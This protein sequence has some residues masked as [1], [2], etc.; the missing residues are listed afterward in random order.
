MKA[1]LRRTNSHFLAVLSDI[2]EVELP[3][4]DVGAQSG[5]SS[6]SES[7]GLTA[8]ALL[9]QPPTAQPTYVEDFASLRL[10]A[11]PAPTIVE[12]RATGGH[13][14]LRTAI[15]AFRP[16]ACSL[17][18][19][20]EGVTSPPTGMFTHQL[21]GQHALYD[22]YEPEDAGDARRKLLELLI[23]VFTSSY[24]E[25]G[26]FDIYEAARKDILRW[27]KITPEEMARATVDEMSDGQINHILRRHRFAPMTLE[28]LQGLPRIYAGGQ[29]GD[30]IYRLIA[31]AKEVDGGNQFIRR[32]G[33]P[34]RLGEY[35]GSAAREKGF[36]GSQR[37]YEH[38]VSHRISVRAHVHVILMTFG[39][40]PQD[41]IAR[42]ATAL[43]T[44]ATKHFYAF[45]YGEMDRQRRADTEQPCCAAFEVVRIPAHLRAR[46]PLLLIEEAITQLTH[47]YGANGSF[48]HTRF[49][50]S[51]GR[52]QPQLSAG[53]NSSRPITAN[54]S[55]KRSLR[56]AYG[57]VQRNL[58]TQYHKDMRTI[59]DF[60]Q[61]LP[62]DQ[63]TAL[64]ADIEACAK[65]LV[66][67][68]WA[69]NPATETDLGAFDIAVKIS[70]HGQKKHG[71]Y[72]RQLY[73]KHRKAFGKAASWSDLSNAQRKVCW[74]L[75]FRG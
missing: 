16:G 71:T 50:E 56:R 45:G 55:G 8:N 64:P 59:Y 12:A 47:G 4:R 74:A 51:T 43:H 39:V 15:N 28:E 19:L 44:L 22:P 6:H 65:R 21:V 40:G 36:S 60:W 24:E 61:S 69:W 75:P 7:S 34:P 73:E 54:V 41:Q 3:R 42:A 33:G 9:A 25:A 62:D 32:E 68:T 57:F 63:E 48:A 49:R 10:N 18:D 67:K 23:A 13:G 30:C 1:R 5:P 72:L 37:I 52:P 38:G 27:R 58:Q 17:E 26:T 31:R 46:A 14:H 2:D 11:L 35:T 20:L 70:Q 66:K 29:T 53:M